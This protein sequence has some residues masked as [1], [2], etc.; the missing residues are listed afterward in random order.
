V[1]PLLVVAD[2]LRSLQETVQAPSAERA[3]ARLSEELALPHVPMDAARSGV[4][5]PLERRRVL[6]RRLVLRLGAAAVAAFAAIAMVSLRA[7]P[8]SF[9][10]PLRTGLEETA[11]L[12]APHDG[13]LR[14]HIAE[15]RLGDL[16]H[17]LTDGP[18]SAAPGLARALVSDRE[19]AVRAG[20][21][22]AGLDA[23]V[24][25]D[26][27]PAL[28]LAAPDI[29]RQVESILG[30]LL[31]SPPVHA[32]TAG[33]GE[34]PGGPSTDST[35]GSSG[36]GSPDAGSGDGGAASGGGAS[37]GS[38]G[39]GSGDTTGDGGSGSGDGGSGSSGGGSGGSGS[40]DTTG[41]GGSGSGDGG[42]G[43]AGSG[44][45]TDGTGTHL[46]HGGGIDTSGGSS[47]D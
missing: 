25:A 39:S 9:L 20:E 15:A 27:P 7:T 44:G 6:R 41:D 37:G 16:V 46:L 18:Q 24:R 17:V 35:D 45:S 11:L 28:A 31:P 42:S 38:G 43:G 47:S 5:V 8:G 30:A 33:P 34:N 21:S 12:V 23:A 3:W 36:R 1:A 2:R 22:V 10:Y 29:A 13:S 40:G 26:V 4:V 19:A 32:L 14:L